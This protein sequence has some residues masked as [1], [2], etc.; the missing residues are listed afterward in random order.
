ML[1]SQVSTSKVDFEIGRLDTF[2]DKWPHP[3]KSY[4]SR[5]KMAQAGFFFSGR[6]DMVQCFCCGIKLEGWDP[7]EDKPWQKHQKTCS[8]G[9]RKKR[10]GELTI[11][12]L[13]DVQA[14]KAKHLIDS[15]YSKTLTNQ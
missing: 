10:E 15:K 11:P 7:E 1:T 4:C 2:T 6:N 12:E 9:L 14:S 13:I 3:D 8:F 5:Q